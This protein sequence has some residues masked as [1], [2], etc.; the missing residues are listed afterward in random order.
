MSDHAPVTDASAW[1]GA[2][3][4]NDA[5]WIGTLTA[6]EVEDL[7]AALRG[8]QARGLATTAIS[9]AD[10]PLPV[11]APRLAAW[12]REAQSGR[13]FFVLRG[14]P[15]G[16]F[17]EAEREAIFWGIGTH[18]GTAV[19]QNSHGEMLGHVFD[20]GR[21]YGSANTRGYQ[22]RARL[23]FHTDRCDLVGLLCQRRA[24]AGGLSSV[25][26]TMAVH[27]EIL[28]TRP[29]L[30]P[31]LYR[32]FHYSEREAADNPNGVTPRPIPVFSRWPDGPGGVLS[33]RFIRNPIETGAQR[34]GVPLT[35]Q[36]REALELMSDLSAREDMRLDMML[37]PGDMQ[38]CNNYVTTHA[39]TEFE[40]WPEPERRRLMVRLWLTVHPRRP[41]APDFGE[42]DGIPA[43]LAPEAAPLPA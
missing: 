4:A 14:L 39:R 3:I 38:F 22:T 32:G 43:R 29:D 5:G 1:R 37:E 2:E 25:V 17:T 19:S 35:E 13:G 12:L 18:L 28:R 33:C 27:N 6:A 36:E 24:K 23:D 26:S 41:L 31:V 30:L 10:F 20:Q 42:H 8:V 7:A 15:A 40:D 34:R 11:L 9:R 21:T 16:R